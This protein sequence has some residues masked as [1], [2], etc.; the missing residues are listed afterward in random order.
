M[1]WQTER[2]N[3]RLRLAEMPVMSRQHAISWAAQTRSFQSLRDKASQR[4]LALPQA[5]N[6]VIRVLRKSMDHFLHVI[7]PGPRPPFFQV[8]EHLWGA[9]C[10]ID[11][12]GNSKTPDDLQWTE[13]TL[14]L[15]GN[16]KQRVDI[17]PISDV[18]LI[19]AVR[20]SHQ[21]LC[22]MAVEFIV[23]VSGGEVRRT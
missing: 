10:I 13:L 19:L 17:D 16:P 21:S 4:R 14:I 6:K 11:S 5:R 3:K 2:S 22:R 20:S 12:D 9:G 7:S 18:P 23:A 8:A 1:R 15:R